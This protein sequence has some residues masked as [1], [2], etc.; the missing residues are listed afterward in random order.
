MTM[1]REPSLAATEKRVFR[2]FWQDGL[3]DIVVG[4]TVFLMGVGALNGLL[5]L[6]PGLPIVGVLVWL[7][8]RRWITEPRLGTVTFSAQRVRRLRQGL[9]AILGFGLVVG[10]S[11]VIGV[12]FRSEGSSFAAWFAPAIPATIVATLSLCCALA[13]GLW[14][15]GVYGLIFLGVGVGAASWRV[16]PWWCLVGGGLVVA[17]W[18]VFMLV[19]FL[20]DF[21]ELS[22]TPER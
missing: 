17:T 19:G 9:I 16:E 3:L 11:V 2:G 5:V 6:M 20:R 8:A 7:A 14:R 18:G 15:Y 22:H 4:A 10:V 1:Y 12:W 21:P 13:L